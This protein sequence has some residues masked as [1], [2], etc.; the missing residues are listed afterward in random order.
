MQSF[1]CI[2]VMYVAKG[3]VAGMFKRGVSP[4]SCRSRELECLGVP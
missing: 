4:Q 1:D 2:V 3:T